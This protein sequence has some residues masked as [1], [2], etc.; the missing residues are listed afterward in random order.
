MGFVDEHLPKKLAAVAN[1]RID[2]RIPL[3]YMVVAFASCMASK[4]LYREGIHFLESQPE[5]RV[6]DLAQRYC[7]EE[8]RINELT[9]K[10]KTGAAFES[11]EDTQELVRLLRHGGV[12]SAL[13]L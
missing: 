6:A 12:R 7:E 3:E 10:V 9:E 2:S 1:D 8:K 5:C 13:H 4:L 11:K